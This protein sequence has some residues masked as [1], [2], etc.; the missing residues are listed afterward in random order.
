MIYALVPAAGKS[1]RMGRPKLALPFGTSTVLERVVGILRSCGLAP[2]VVVLA[3]GEEKLAALANSAGARVVYVPSPTADMRATVGHGLSWI[4]AALQPAGTDFWLLAPADHP[5]LDARTVFAL[6]H[7]QASAPGYLVY[8]PVYEDRKG[9]PTLVSWQVVEE[10]RAAPEAQGLHH[11]FRQMAA[12][13]L[14]VPVSSPSVLW[15]LDTEEDYQRLL[16]EHGFD[17]SSPSPP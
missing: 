13:T 7:A 15:D 3:P 9:H 2:V 17:S 8:V 1:S 4:E 14:R 10:I 6:L 12:R 16:R 11:L 5:T